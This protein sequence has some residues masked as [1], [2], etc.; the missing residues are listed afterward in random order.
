MDANIFFYLVKHQGL[1]LQMNDVLY[2][3]L[4]E[5]LPSF[6]LNKYLLY[7]LKFQIIKKRQIKRKENQIDF[8]FAK[9]NERPVK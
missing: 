1:T 6:E 9:L 2:V 3:F 4:S 5:H 7:V 8:E